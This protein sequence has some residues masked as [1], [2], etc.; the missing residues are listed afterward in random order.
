MTDGVRGNRSRKKSPGNRNRSNGRHRRGQYRPNVGIV[1]LNAD[2]KVFWARRVNHDGW[3]FPQG[4]VE[5][6]ESVE[7][8][9]FRELYEEVGLESEK[10]RLVGRTQDWL[11]Y[12]LPRRYLRPRSNFRGQKQVWFLLQL[13]GD[14]NDVSLQRSGHPEFDKWRWVDYW[15]PIEWIV[16]FKRDVYRSALKELEPLLRSCQETR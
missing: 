3:Q 8:A 5:P 10:V 6:N 4:G 1:L 15:E 14:D 16:D 2:N 7:Q 12:D 11:H 9:V 13:I